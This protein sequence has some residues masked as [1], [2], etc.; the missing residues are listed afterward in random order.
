MRKLLCMVMLSILLSA[1]GGGSSEPTTPIGT[2]VDLTAFKGVYL[3]TAAGSQYN[4][5]SLSGGDSL[6]RAWTG[7]YSRTAYGSTIFETNNVTQSV[8]NINLQLGATS[9]GSIG[10]SYFLLSDS[11]FYK[12]VSSTG[13]TALPVTQFPIPSSPKV[14][15][16]G[17]I[18]T[19]NHSDGTTS[20]A[21]WSLN[22]DVNGGS[23]LVFST[24]I[25]TGT[26]VT[27]T[28]TDTFYLDSTGSPT[29]M[30]IK[31][32]LTSPQSLTV[33]LSGNRVP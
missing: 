2:T 5:P 13:M 22:A 4:F 1:C 33:N 31:V 10:T 14:G 30:A 3:G 26:A 15:D 9:S 7:S 16:V 12:G 32:T 11:S 21:T 20:T 27:S 25:K 6:G 17:V 18:G 8:T 23:Q 19:L 28:E 29:R 24:A